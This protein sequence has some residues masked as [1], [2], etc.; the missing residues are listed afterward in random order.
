M[1]RMT[2]KRIVSI[3]VKA[4]ADDAQLFKKAA[5][6]WPGAPI[7]RSSYVLALARMG[8]EHALKTG[9]KPA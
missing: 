9:K 3:S 1:G 4:T 2:G 7:T 5:N 8:A 6:M